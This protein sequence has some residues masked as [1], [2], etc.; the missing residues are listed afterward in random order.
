VKVM[1]LNG[2]RDIDNFITHPSKIPPPPPDPE[3][4]LRKAE[5]QTQIQIQQAKGIEAQ[6]KA[7]LEREKARLETIRLQ[8]EVEKARAELELARADSHRKDMQ[9][10]NE[11]DI[12]QREIAIVE[13]APA[14]EPAKAIVS[15]NS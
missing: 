5:M 15:P 9:I 8:I 4:E 7:E 14:V 10:A 11:I 12:S 2:I 1:T 3:V 13:A 6:A